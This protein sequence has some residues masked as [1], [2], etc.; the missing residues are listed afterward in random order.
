MS[1]FVKVRQGTPEWDCARSGLI[2]ASMAGTA[3]ETVGGLNAQQQLYVDT[4]FATGDKADAMR[5]AGYKQAPTAG[6]VQQALDGT[7]ILQPSDAA[8]KY[9]AKLA[10]ERISGNPFGEPVK[11]WV[12]ERGHEMEDQA[13][14]KYEQRFS[15]MLTDPGFCISDCGLFGYSTD[16]R[17]D[18]GTDQGLV[19]FKGP[20]D[21]L[22]ILTLMQTRD[23][24]EYTHQ[25]QFGMWLDNRQWCDWGM[26]VPDL[27][28]C[29]NG[30][31]I[32]RVPRDQAFID[33][34]VQKLHRFNLM[35]NEYVDIFRGKK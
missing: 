10:L 32:I 31:F 29:D 24:S 3:Y 17:V 9:A 34:M 27:D 33:D 7:L 4:Y 15:V 13:R 25:M 21:P 2:T 23:L 18:D 22:K 6:V 20:I 19:E 35:V 8:R 11:A 30:L 26:R 14:M 16:G 28:A 1:H 5:V 12:L